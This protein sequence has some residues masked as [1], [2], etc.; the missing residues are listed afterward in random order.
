MTTLVVTLFV[1]GV[2]MFIFGLRTGIKA[3][4]YRSNAQ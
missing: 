2:A 4:R 1:A 3:M